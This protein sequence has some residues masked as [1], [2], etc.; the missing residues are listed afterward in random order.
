MRCEVKLSDEERTKFNTIMRL[1]IDDI[2]IAI[3]DAMEKHNINTLPREFAPSF[4]FSLIINMACI[5]AEG[6]S[7]RNGIINNK[8]YEI[9][10]KDLLELLEKEMY[11]R[12]PINGK[13]F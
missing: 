6:L 12:D 7:K 13:N 2:F 5:T 3:A 8:S 10:K 4:Y 1:F 11:I 9:Y